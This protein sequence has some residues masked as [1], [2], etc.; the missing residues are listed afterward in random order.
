VILDEAQELSAMAW[1][2]VM[3]RIPT[4]SL[5]V[6]GD[7]AQTGSAAG[8]RTWE[9]VLAP[10]AEDRW[11]E[12]RLMINYRT[13]AEIMDVAADVLRAVAPDQVPPQSVR[14]GE[15]PPRA[16]RQTSLD[17]A[18][19]VESELTAIGEGRLA[20]IVPNARHTGFAEV[21]LEAPVVVL[22]VTQSK[23]LEFDAVVVVAPDE[24]LAQS[25]KGGHDLYV[26]ITRATKRLAVVHEAELPDM[27]AKLAR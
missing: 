20:V 4:R 19:V 26:A 23:G 17:F 6:V 2:S 12:E 21:D 13:P 15:T 10:Y 22:T 27:L 24:I 8:A 7:I 16:I 25:P 3:R 18:D 14:T 9:E 1:R 5:T 11:R